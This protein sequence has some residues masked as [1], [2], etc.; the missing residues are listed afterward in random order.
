[1][2][3]HA[4]GDV[5]SSIAIGELAALDGEAHGSDALEHLEQAIHRAHKR[6][7]QRVDQ[8]PELAGMGTTI[9]ALLR[10]GDRLALAHIGDS[11][12][13]LLSGEEFTQVTRDHTFVQWLIDQGRITPEEADVH[14]QR[15]VVMRV[16]GDVDADDELDTSVRTAKVG[17]RWL[18]C[19]DGLSG[20]VSDETLAR[21][22]ADAGSPEDC[23]DKLIELALR[24]GGQDNIT[25]IVAD[26]VDASSAPS[27]TPQVVGA[28]AANRK[29]TS[30]AEGSPA[31]KAAALER[32]T[33]PNAD[34]E[35]GDTHDERGRSRTLGATV[36]G[37]GLLAVLV[38]AALFGYRWSQQQ[39]FVGAD[40]QDVAIYK[41]LSQDVG[42][43]KLSHLY[44]KQDLPLDALPAVWRD[45]VSSGIPADDLGHARQIVNTLL[46]RSTLCQAVEPTTQP[47]QAAPAPAPTTA[48]T[49]GAAPTPTP[50][51]SASGSAA[52]TAP[53]PFPT[54]IPTNSRG[55]V[56]PAGCS[57]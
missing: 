8:D 35:D 51:V 45:R 49:A 37:I 14:P 10:S 50:S 12:A 6:M 41:G 26:V 18:L 47:T 39:F 25:C 13:Y 48:P 19:S 55:Q 32:T 43:V 20:F 11:R 16:L 4:G 5:A 1:M 15:S 29:R 21:T 34:D 9:T 52:P 7:H 24:G 40:A 56:L 27:T 3:G 2:G 17:D 36:A 22:L 28:A 57:G 38:A 53:A 42:P 33:E 30:V 54:P 46:Q 31:A 23:A 44:E